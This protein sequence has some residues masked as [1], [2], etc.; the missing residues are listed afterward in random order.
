[1]IKKGQKI[2]FINQLLKAQTK[3]AKPSQWK[4]KQVLKVGKWDICSRTFFNKQ[5]VNLQQTKKI[6]GNTLLLKEKRKVVGNQ[7]K[8][9][10]DLIRSESVGEGSRSSSPSPK[11]LNAEGKEEKKE[12]NETKKEEEM[13]QSGGSSERAGDKKEDIGVQC[14]IETN[15]S[16][17]KQGF[18]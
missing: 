11:R 1:M 12:N 10:C 9:I 17:L 18:L 5:G 4:R 6:H 14:N 3:T 15:L 13:E 16:D 8:V 2:F 7:S